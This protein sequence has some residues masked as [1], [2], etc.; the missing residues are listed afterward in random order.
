MFHSQ[1]NSSFQNSL[2]AHHIVGPLFSDIAVHLQDLTSGFQAD[3]ES[4]D[5]IRF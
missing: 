3:V 1:F 4:A 5:N 2:W